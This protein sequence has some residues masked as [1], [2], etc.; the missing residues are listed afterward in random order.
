L[1]ITVEQVGDFTL[2]ADDG[3]AT[4]GTSTTTPATRSRR[5]RARLVAQVQLSS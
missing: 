5:H 1:A 3:V 4:E 2:A